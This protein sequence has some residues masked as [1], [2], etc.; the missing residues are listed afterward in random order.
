MHRLTIRLPE[1]MAESLAREARVREVSV[2]AVARE[3]IGS[4]LRR[5]AA[6]DARRAL[7]FAALGASDET[8][9][10]SRIETILAS[11]WNRPRR[12]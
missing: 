2:S 6:S 4:H 12:S 7:P 8:D 1:E 9:V 5:A 10:A 3:A 11:E